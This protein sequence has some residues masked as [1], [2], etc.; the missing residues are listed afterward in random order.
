MLKSKRIIIALNNVNL[1]RY[2][3]DKVCGESHTNKQR[4]IAGV[5]I[6]CVGVGFTKLLTLISWETVHFL[7]EIIGYSLHGIGLI[8]FVHTIEKHKEFI[9]KCK[10]EEEDQIEQE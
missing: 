8:P 7:G 5:I 4:K 1:S 10:D 6:M 9:Q 3:S 2:L